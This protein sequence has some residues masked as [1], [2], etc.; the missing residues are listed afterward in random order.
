MAHRLSQP[1]LQL[2][3]DSEDLRLGKKKEISEARG[4]KEVSVLSASL[5]SLVTELTVQKADLAYA[6][7]SQESQ[8][9]ERTRQLASQNIDLVQAKIAAERATEAKSKFLAA[10]SHDLRQ[11]LHAMTLF[12]RALSRRVSGDEAPV[13][14]SQLEEALRALKGMFDALLDVS[15]LDAKMIAPQIELVSV[16]DV[17]DRVSIGV[18]AEAEQ[19]RLHFRSR[20]ADWLLETDAAL[21]ETI[22]RN[23]V[24]N[25]LKFTQHG[26][27]LLAARRRRGEHVID[28]YDTGPG[29]PEDRY[30]KIFQEFARTNTRASGM[31]DGLGFG[32]SIARRYSE[33]LG[34]KVQV[35][36]RPGH[37]SRFTIILP[38]LALPDQSSAPAIADHTASQPAAS[39]FSF[40]MMIP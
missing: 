11:P 34:M 20:R 12:A 5:R 29:L 22:L 19:S 6:N 15:R 39:A 8:V 37:G 1:L 31:N 10:A 28:V 17:I 36:S 27:I 13:L 18:R 23:L 4:Y 35:C 7:A 24:S 25:S 26:G 2:A 3:A 33:L 14:V 16:G 32:L 40:S 38:Q 30:E 21:F 9:Q